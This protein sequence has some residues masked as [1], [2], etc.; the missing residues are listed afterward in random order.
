MRKR[1]RGFTLLEVMVALA[2]IVIAL[3][4]L[5]TT[6]STSIKIMTRSTLMTKAYLLAEKKLAALELAGY[7]VIEDDDGSFEENP[8]LRWEQRVAQA[9]LEGLK[10]VRIHILSGNPERERK[11]AAF[12]TFIS[13][14]EEPEEEGEK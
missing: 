6:Q 9:D 7:D 11:E 4:A 2:I 13:E 8:E 14:L 12:T 3:V 5:L 1:N 10:E